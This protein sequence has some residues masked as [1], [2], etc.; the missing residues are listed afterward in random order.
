MV[1]VAVLP[2]TGFLDEVSAVDD[3]DGAEVGTSAWL[4]CGATTWQLRKC[5][6]SPERQAHEKRQ[7]LHRYVVTTSMKS[8][9]R[10]TC[11]TTP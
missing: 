8:S 3:L 10:S 4:S 5:D 9:S 11:R 7:N 1:V 2:L 6:M